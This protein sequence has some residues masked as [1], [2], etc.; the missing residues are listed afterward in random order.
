MVSDVTFN[1][2]SPNRKQVIQDSWLIDIV[3]SPW[4]N[5][6]Y[7]AVEDGFFEKASRILSDYHMYD[8][9]KKMLEG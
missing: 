3:T 9:S 8:A 4:I 6:V 1:R 2:L 7:E 5:E